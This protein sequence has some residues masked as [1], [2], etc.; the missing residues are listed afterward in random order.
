MVYDL[1]SEVVILQQVNTL[2]TQVISMID[3]QLYG[4]LHY[5]KCI[6]VFMIM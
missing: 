1:P 2:D 4:Y 6:N 3:H 5:V